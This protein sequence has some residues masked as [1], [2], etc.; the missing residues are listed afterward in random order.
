[1]GPKDVKYERIVLEPSPDM[2]KE[3][4]TAKG[5]SYSW[6]NLIYASPVCRPWYGKYKVFAAHKRLMGGKHKGVRG[7]KSLM[8]GKPLMFA[9]PKSLMGGKPLMFAAHKPL[10]GG[11]HKGFAAHKGFWGTYS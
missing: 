4:E 3:I 8:G 1:M 6:G 9:A 11:K 2:E 5:K 7:P 10:M